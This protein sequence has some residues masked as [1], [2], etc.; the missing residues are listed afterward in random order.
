MGG[1]FKAG[2][3][4]FINIKAIEETRKK[5]EKYM[6]KKFHI[7]RKLKRFLWI[8]ETALNKFENISGQIASFQIKPKGLNNFN[9]QIQQENAHVMERLGPFKIIE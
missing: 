8:N 2:Y 6:I 3:Y 1:N 4:G 9:H 5:N 7:Q